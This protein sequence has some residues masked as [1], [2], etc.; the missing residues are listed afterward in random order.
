VSRRFPPLTGA[1]RRSGPCTA[2]TRW[3]FCPGFCLTNVLTSG[4]CAAQPGP[5]PICRGTNPCLFFNGIFAMYLT[6]PARR[7]A[8][9]LA[10]LSLT[11]SPAAP[12]H[13]TAHRTAPMQGS[14]PR[15][16]P[17]PLAL[18]PH[19]LILHC[20][21]A[22]RPGRPPRPLSAEA[23]AAW[24]TLMRRPSSAGGSGWP[25]SCNGRSNLEALGVGLCR[26]LKLDGPMLGRCTGRRQG[27]ASVW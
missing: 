4:P 12:P 23:A 3:C 2:Q 11:P 27:H 13:A 24:P 9:G 8:P 10:C 25:P 20:S 15:G 18:L 21:G 22:R 26:L 7:Q 1:L 16:V 14:G 6:A 17:W 5:R 19:A